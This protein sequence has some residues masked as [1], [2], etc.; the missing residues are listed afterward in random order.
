[1]NLADGFR[2]EPGALVRQIISRNT[3]NGRIAKVHLLD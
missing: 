3:G 2:V 1:M